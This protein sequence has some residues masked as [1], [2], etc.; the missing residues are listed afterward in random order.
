L[1][2]SSFAAEAQAET[3]SS[4]APPETKYRAAPQAYLRTRKIN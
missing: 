2:L 3:D 1:I 4:P